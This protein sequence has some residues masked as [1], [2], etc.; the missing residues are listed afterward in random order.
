VVAL[1]F[2]HQVVMLEAPP[3]ARRIGDESDIRVVEALAG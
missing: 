2:S 3:A 1:R